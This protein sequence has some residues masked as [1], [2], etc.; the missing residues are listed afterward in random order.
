METVFVQLEESRENVLVSFPIAVIKH[1]AKSKLWEKGHI[2]AD[3]L[4]QSIITSD[5]IKYSMTGSGYLP[6]PCQSVPK[7]SR[8]ATD[9]A[10]KGFIWGRRG[11][12]G[13]ENR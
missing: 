5:V 4:V 10:Y 11:R 7:K 8:H 3:S 9:L 1:S 13:L 2:Q 12:E 6:G